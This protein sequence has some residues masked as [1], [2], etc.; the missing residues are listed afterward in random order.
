MLESHPAFLRS[1]Q[2]VLGLAR[3]TK[4]KASVQ[5]SLRSYKVFVYN[6]VYW[7]Q[8]PGDSYQ[9]GSTYYHAQYML[10]DGGMISTNKVRKK[11]ALIGSKQW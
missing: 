1:R 9:G 11:Q 3:S 10:Y 7:G 8:Q 6:N 2:S 5:R 4:V